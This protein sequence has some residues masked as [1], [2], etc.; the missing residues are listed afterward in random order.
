MITTGTIIAFV[1]WT[2]AMVWLGIEVGVSATKAKYE[3]KMKIR[4]VRTDAIHQAEIDRRK[5]TWVK[6]DEKGRFVK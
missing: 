2:V 4:K 1:A 5:V 6:R 3:E